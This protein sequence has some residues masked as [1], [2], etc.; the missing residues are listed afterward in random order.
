MK[1]LLEKLSKKQL[2]TASLISVALYFGTS[3]VLENLYAKSKF[4]VS[5]FEA[6]TSFDA[7][8]IKG[9]Y[10]NLLDFGTMDIYYQTQFFDFVFIATVI[11]MGFTLW[12]LFGSLIAKKSWQYKNR[13]YLSLFL[14]I[15]GLFDILENVVSF[16]MLANPTSFNINLVYIYSGFA[17]LKFLCWSIALLILILLIISWPI[18]KLFGNRQSKI[19]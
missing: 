19:A 3:Y 8:K 11:I 12:M 18:Q 6:Q 7:T 4:P 9:W 1:S 5:Y 13:Y 15:A 2:I 16:F 17:S 14:P 10:Q